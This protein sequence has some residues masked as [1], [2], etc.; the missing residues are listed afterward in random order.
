MTLSATLETPQARNGVSRPSFPIKTV[1]IRLDEIGY[2][3][4]Q[5]TMRTNP[6]SS[7][8]DALVSFDDEGKWWKAFGEVVIEWNF[9]GEDGGAL[10]HPKDCESEHD[11][12]LPYGV[13]AYVIKRYFEE[14]KAQVEL[15]KAQPVDSAP[16]SSTSAGSPPSE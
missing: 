8:Y 5:V 9:V 14:F 11:L 10:D 4:W 2:E 6:R 7:I 1:T 12:D 13:M 3:G 15:P 16:T